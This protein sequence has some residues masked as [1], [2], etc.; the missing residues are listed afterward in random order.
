MHRLV[1]GPLLACSLLFAAPAWAQVQLDRYLKQDTYGR[2]KIS[3]D[4]QYYAATVQLEDRVGLAIL[5]RSDKK[6]VN[7]ATGARNS[8]VDDFWWVG[9]DRVVIAM[10][11]RMGS[12]DQPYRTGLLYA[13]A[14]DGKRARTLLGAKDDAN[15]AASIDFNPQW[16]MTDLI[17]P[18]PG[19][20]RKVLISAW[21]LG[22]DPL[23]TVD[24]LDVYTGL[25]T[26]VATAPVNRASFLT[27]AAGRVRF[28]RG[29]NK[30]NYTQLYY[31]EDD[32]A[33]W[34][35]VNDE[36]ATGRNEAAVGFSADGQ[37]AYLEVA[38][39]GGTDS[40]VAWDTKTG[41]RRQVLRDPVVDP[42]AIVYDRDSRTVLGAQYMDGPVSS[43]M[44]DPDD[45]Q[46]RRY[47]AIEKAFA[48]SAVNVTSL[49]RDGVALVQVWN[50]RTPGDTY[51]FDPRT[52]HADGVFA[53][54]EWFDPGK[55]PKM[56]PVVLK[57]RDGLA[58][59][60]YLTLP[61][62]T[63]EGTPVPMVVMPH[64]GPYGVFDEWAFDDDT[65]L[66]A[67]AGYAVL[68]INFRGSGN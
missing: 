36:A 23:T 46:S 29:A 28:A 63:A 10:A 17:D 50:D 66:L 24:L 64:G 45:P 60:G 55:L 57:A 67:E 40:L 16:E 31:R 48:G 20:P 47:L 30:Q 42:Y 59:H 62:G 51:L 58:L 27:D 53:Q 26:P 65:Q 9:D 2:I 38:Q 7:G 61:A 41:E 39:P 1:A 3:P 37:V 34:R 15:V 19:D 18:L 11:E 33:P 14:V 56:R 35:L 21:K 43:R 49:T 54:R 25:R 44:L 4:G 68:R 32:D 8:V 5:R 6:V 12:R 22:A 13:L 52:M